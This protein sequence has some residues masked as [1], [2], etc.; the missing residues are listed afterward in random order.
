MNSKAAVYSSLYPLIYNYL[1][2]GT[3]FCPFAVGR[4][5]HNIEHEALGKQQQPEGEVGKLLNMSLK[6]L[7]EHNN[8]FH[9]SFNC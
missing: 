5:W 4:V 3:L 1:L 6:L 2:L 9:C 7:W 8:L